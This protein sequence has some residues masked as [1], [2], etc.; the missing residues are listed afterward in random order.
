[1]AQDLSRSAFYP[2]KHFSSVRAQQGRLLT[3]DDVNEGDAIDKEDMRRTRADVIGDSGSPNDGFKISQP[4][5]NAGHID[6]SL[7][8]G[9][10]YAGGLRATLE[11]PETYALQKDWL[12]QTATDRQAPAAERIDLV[13]LE[14]WQQPV[15]AVEDGELREVA[16]HVPDTSV[17]LRTMRRAHVLSNVGTENCADAWAKLGPL[18]PGNEKTTNATLTVGFVPNGTKD[19]LCSPSTVTGYLGAENQAIRVEIGSAGKFRWSFDNAS[20]LYRVRLTKDVHGNDV[21]HFLQAPKDENHWPLAGQ[22]VEVLPW[23]ALLPN[24][25]KVSEITGGWLTTVSASYDPDT[26]NIAVNPTVQAGFGAPWQQRSDVNA[27]QGNPPDVYFYLRVWNHGGA[28]DLVTETPFVPATAVGLPGTG[29]T[30][31]FGGT[32]FN[33]GDFW[34]IAARPNDPAKVVPWSFGSGKAAEGVRRFYAPLGLIHWR[35]ATNQHTFFDCRNVFDPLTRQRG[36]C[37]VVSP[38]DGWEHVIDETASQSDICICFQPGDFVT[39]RTLVLRNAHVKIH[40]AGLASRVTGTGLDT[41]FKF[42]GCSS[43]EISD[44]SVRST[45][46]AVHAGLPKP[47]RAGTITVRN[48]DDARLENLAVRC[49]PGTNRSAE[50]ISL[51]NELSPDRALASV[52]RIKGCELVVGANQN[53]ISVI[54]FGRS[55]VED[56]NLRVDPAE[57]AQIPDSWLRIKSF[58]RTFRRSLLH[59]FGVI[60]PTH[61]LPAGA[62]QIA[63][64]NAQV[65]IKSPEQ[66]K[67]GWLAAIPLRRFK[68]KTINHRSVGEYLNTMAEDLVYGEGSLGPHGIPAFASYIKLILA[69]RTAVTR[70]RMTASQGIVVAGTVVREARV[71]GNSVRDFTQGIHVG[72][73]QHSLRK[74]VAPLSAGRVEVTSNAVHI[75]LMPE[76]HVER[77]GIFVG[78]TD[79]LVIENNRLECETLAAPNLITEGIRVYGFL[80]SMA[81]VTRNHLS[82]FRTGIRVSPFRAP[83]STVFLWRVTDNVAA[84][85]AATVANPL[86]STDLVISGNRP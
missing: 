20:P 81:F 59:G 70:V 49:A 21:I 48:C 80:G 18:G 34:I 47:H 77:H 57:N 30:V 17:R 82:G 9:T 65:W 15:T 78:N 4:I 86:N 36:C 33:A 22:I 79:S 37:V 50:C 3:D 54:N 39:T 6:F 64:G 40:G 73:S 45:S 5:I 31:T 41:V 2:S 7:A 61:P 14:V 74:G 38:H 53:G 83:G 85:A 71:S 56:N 23:S 19:N 75:T 67:P 55:T 35:P 72:V 44:L 29:L 52:A 63:L 32:Q 13:Y 51:Y 84:S 42:D 10:I 66:V 11:T 68:A 43:V 62:F 24:G 58:R 69:V 28:S 1:M 76:S 25:E 27:I 8:A 16:L 12:Q 26:Q 60:D 46:Q